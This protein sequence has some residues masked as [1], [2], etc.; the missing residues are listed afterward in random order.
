MKTKKK[1]SVIILVIALSLAL[2]GTF[3]LYNE[4]T[5]SAIYDSSKIIG[6]V[7]SK[8]IINNVETVINKLFE[9]D[10]TPGYDWK[11]DFWNYSPV[12]VFTI[13]GVSVRVF[14]SD[15][16]SKINA[17]QII[18]PDGKINSLIQK[19]ISN[20]LRNYDIQ[21]ELSNTIIDWIDADNENMHLGAEIDY[22]QTTPFKLSCPN[23]EMTS[24][25]ELKLLKGLGVYFD[26]N[27]TVDLNGYI[28]VF[29]DNLYNINT[30]S[31]EVLSS[32]D[33][34]DEVEIEAIINF[35]KDYPVKNISDMPKFIPEL[36][37]KSFELIDGYLKT[38]SDIIRIEIQTE[39]SGVKLDYVWIYDKTQKKVLYK[40]FK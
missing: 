22:Y 20:I 30:V 31:P 33:F 36:Q 21:E 16:D 2:L 17:N 23:N 1:G 39:Y 6:G 15:E 32:F 35:R 14:F 18:Y 38:T 5:K 19:K 8:N 29:G 4:I 34:L 13:D 10:L 24:P 26:G 9:T 3:L 27:D 11:E 37:K 40:Q 28:T 12:I 25:D 7:K